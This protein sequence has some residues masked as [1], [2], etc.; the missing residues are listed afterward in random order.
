MRMNPSKLPW[1]I[2]GACGLT[3]LLLTSTG[4]AEVYK[5]VDASG[6]THYS[7]RK[8]DA[9]GARTAEVKIAP[10]P[11][12]APMPEPSADYL[13]AQ[14][15]FAPPPATSADSLA[16]RSASK[17]P[18]LLSDGQDHGTDDSRCALARDVLSG[19]VVHR[20]GKPTDN[21]DR[22]VARNDVKAFCRSR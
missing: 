14:S 2:L 6:R 11:R 21:Y 9:N 13:R 18:V 3:L 17:A 15:K 12:L 5:W 4:H 16:R 1:P 7:E 8:A 19:A 10:A 22:E 20:N